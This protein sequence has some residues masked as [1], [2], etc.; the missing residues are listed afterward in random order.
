LNL[1]A[2]QLL[3]ERV[4]AGWMPA[5]AAEASGVSRATVY[6]WLRRFRQ[7]GSTGLLDRSSRPH[8][9]PSRTSAVQEAILLALRRQRK[10]GPHRLAPLTGCPR[11]T[12]YAILR[13]HGVHRLDWLDRPSGLVVRRYEWPH[14]GDLGHLDVKKLGRIPP[15]GGHR[16]HGRLGFSGRS[17]RHGYDF[18]H[19][20]V[21][22]HSRLAYCEVLSDEQGTTSASFLRRAIGFFAAHGITF[23]R[24]MT[25]N[26]FAYCVSRPFQ[27]TLAELGIQHRRTP[28]RRPQPNGKVE[29]FNRTLLDE[30]AYLRAYAS[31]DERVGL[32]P[33]WLHSY[34]YHRAHTAL[35]GV[36]PIARVNKV[37]GNYS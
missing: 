9:S 37:P 32:L 24:L 31:N 17:H 19:S 23:R 28:P 11:S 14:P 8:R 33:E 10:L 20:L 36:P 1:F 34:N 2:R 22:D 15:G 6:K 30:W 3:V 25:D 29:R 18:I 5:T 35:G 21:D 13:R 7:E 12:C 26:A 16:V 4:R 27:A